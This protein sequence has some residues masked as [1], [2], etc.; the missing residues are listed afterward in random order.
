MNEFALLVIRVNVTGAMLSS[1]VKVSLFLRSR[2]GQPVG[3]DQPSHNVA[4]GREHVK[5]KPV[6][7]Q[8]NNSTRD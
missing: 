5:C 8:G 7:R 6:A 1:C 2:I 3:L 4:L